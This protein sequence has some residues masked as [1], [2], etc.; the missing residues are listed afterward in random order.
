MV[1]VAY[2]WQEA[3]LAAIRYLDLVGYTPISV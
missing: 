2:T 1:V 3:A